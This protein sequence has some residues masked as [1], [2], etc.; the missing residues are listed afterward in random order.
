MVEAQHGINLAREGRTQME[1]VAGY[2]RVS[3][4][5]LVI[6]LPVVEALQTAA[7]VKT[8]H[9]QTEPVA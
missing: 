6:G 4:S 8:G 5:N 7:L 1:V 9:C 2:Q 3:P